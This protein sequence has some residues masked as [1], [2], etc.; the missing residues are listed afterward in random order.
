MVDD[1]I[2]RDKMR[3]N[4]FIEICNTNMFIQYVITIH[5]AYV[6]GF[7]LMKP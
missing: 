7:I 5:I 4:L 6:N 2:D 1:T 3:P